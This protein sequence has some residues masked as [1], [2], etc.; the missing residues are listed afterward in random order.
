M[1]A[2]RHEIGKAACALRRPSASGRV[3]TGPKTGKRP[4]DG[5]ESWR[6]RAAPMI[7]RYPS[8]ARE[9]F[10]R[11]H[12]SRLWNDALFRS[13]GSSRSRT[14][15][16]DIKGLTGMCDLDLAVWFVEG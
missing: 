1:Q 13:W 2:A 5:V 4:N 16:G 14:I 3:G 7:D 6:R 15:E 8:L 10:W 11:H 12:M 9:T